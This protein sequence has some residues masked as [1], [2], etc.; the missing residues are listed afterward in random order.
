MRQGNVV[1]EEEKAKKKQ[2]GKVRTEWLFCIFLGNEEQRGWMNVLKKS[3]KVREKRE[4]RVIRER[5]QINERV[6]WL[7]SEGG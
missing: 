2:K 5:E 6:S 3:G 7:G 1:V 4:E